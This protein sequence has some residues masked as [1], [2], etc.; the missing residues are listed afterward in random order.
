MK[1]EI[2]KLLSEDLSD[3]GR[4]GGSSTTNWTR[5]FYNKKTAQQ[6]AVSDYGNQIKWKN[7]PGRLSSG[8]LGYVMYTIDVLDIVGDP[9]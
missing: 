7:Q 5:Y 2:F 1:P 4:Q 8:D 9:V 3:V 6:Y